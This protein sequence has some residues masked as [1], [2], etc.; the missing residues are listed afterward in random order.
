MAKLSF[1]EKAYIEKILDM[2]GGYVLNLSNQK[3]QEFIFSV[4]GFDVYTRF[5][6]ESKAKLL[7]KILS[8]CSGIEVGKLILELLE[9]KKS[10]IGVGDDEK[11]TFMKCVD[12]ANNLIGKKVKSKVV[13]ENKKVEKESFNFEE[14][15]AAL[16]DLTAIENSQKTWICI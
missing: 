9:Y 4:L 11:E 7:R 14:S 6:Y 8:D 16:C 2:S 15:F 1:N 5:E 10:H 12:I 13:K 3:F